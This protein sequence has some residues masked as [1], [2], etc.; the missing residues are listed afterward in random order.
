[1]RTAG[2]IPY[3]GREIGFIAK[4]DIIAAFKCFAGFVGGQRAQRFKAHH[5]RMTV[6]H[7]RLHATDG[8]YQ[9]FVLHHFTGLF[10]DTTFFAHATFAIRQDWHHIERQLTAKK[11]IL[12]NRNTVQE[13]RTL[14]G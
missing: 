9:A 7:R 14:P 6:K 5:L 8:N 4:G 10:N 12:I 2:C 13:F 11:I 1:M 3:L